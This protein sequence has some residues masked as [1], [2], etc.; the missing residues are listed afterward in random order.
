MLQNHNNHVNDELKSIVEKYKHPI[1]SNKSRNKTTVQDIYPPLNNTNS[2][3]MKKVFLGVS[4]GSCPSFQNNKLLSILTFLDKFI[5]SSVLIGDSLY[6]NSLKIQYGLSSV[7]AKSEEK[8]ITKSVLLHHKEINFKAINKNRQYIM[9]RDIEKEKLFKEIHNDLKLLLKRDKKTKE[10]FHGFTKF[11][12]DRVSH[13]GM[14][15]NKC[16]LLTIDYLLRE[17]SIFGTLSEKGYEALVYPGKISTIANI[18]D[19]CQPEI[20]KYF[21]DFSF[22][23]LRLK[24][25]Q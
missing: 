18:L 6:Q 23:S 14:D 5:S 12:L 20:K 11:Y 1:L 9:C 17:L 3:F 7:E 22:I 10:I 4:I 8:I 21:S 2:V 25:R 24:R 16:K 19:S 13:I 15:F